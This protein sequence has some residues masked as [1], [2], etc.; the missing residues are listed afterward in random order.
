M[1]DV[2]IFNREV[3]ADGMA[4][5]WETQF[6]FNPADATDAAQDKDGDGR[7]NLQEYLAGSLPTGSVKRY[8]V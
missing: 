7:T 4:D 1:S 6:G 2:Y 3:D 5:D 8:F